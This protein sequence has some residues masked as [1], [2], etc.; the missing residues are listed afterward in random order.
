MLLNIT[1]LLIISLLIYLTISTLYIE[2][3]YAVVATKQIE[4]ETSERRAPVPSHLV[5]GEH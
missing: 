2:A 4:T 3:R 5:G 1:L